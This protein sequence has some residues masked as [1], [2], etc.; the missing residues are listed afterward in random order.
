MSEKPDKWIVEAD[1]KTLQEAM[2]AGEIRAV[3]LV[4]FYVKRIE[5]CNKIINAVLEI[6]PDALQIAQALDDERQKQGSRGPL[7]GIPILLKDNIDTGDRM[8][9]SAGSMAL[10]QSFAAEDA[11][12]A[13]KLRES[14]AVLLGKV[15]MTE[16][17]NF[18]SGPMPSGYSSRG[19][20]V[21][22]PYGPGRFE[23]GG[24]SSG[25]GAATAAGF[26]AAAIG[27]ETSGS[28]VNPAHHNS[29]VG[30]KPTVG[31]LSRI[32]IIPISHSQDT[33][34]PMTRTVMDAA[35]LLGALTGVD[36]RDPLSLASEGNS[37]REKDYTTFLDAN[38]LQGAR[39]GIPRWFY[40]DLN[41]EEQRIAENA[42]QV[43]REQGAVVID[44]VSLPCEQ[45]EWNS[46]V[47]RYEFKKDLNDYLSKLDASV[48]VHTLQ[49]VIAFNHEHA[50]KALVYGQNTL[51]WSDETSGTLTED[52][53]HRNLAKYQELTRS[54]GIDHV[55]EEHQL[56]ALF[57]PGDEGYDIAARA[58]YPLL[59]VPAGYTAEGPM[60]VM[61]SAG[62]FSEGKLLAL[63][64]AFELATKYRRP[65]NL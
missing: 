23:V 3:D 11:F 57:F 53:Y 48:P 21:L 45:A 64:Y 15:N 18:M 65:P 51:I 8:H 43:L 36:A 12:I 26:A 29:L 6:N 27:T 32:G 4:A 31:L 19:G 38:S 55:L 62:A 22:N 9:T 7:H 2:E 54:R 50:E 5:K 35:L 24:S 44:P 16:W 56:D 33:P 42:I 59:N 13:A 49:E 25:S 46:D 10:A 1:I 58:G 40:K 14:G 52:E 20:Q 61:F 63:G 60:G 41:E 30:L 28:I 37:P 47:L 39:I 17:A 34:G